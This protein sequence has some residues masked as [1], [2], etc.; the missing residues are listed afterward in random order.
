MK[1]SITSKIE[2]LLSTLYGYSLPQHK[3]ANKLPSEEK[4]EKQQHRCNTLP[5]EF[6][7]LLF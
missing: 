7:R 1:K 6:I 2:A 5:F 3:T 4:K